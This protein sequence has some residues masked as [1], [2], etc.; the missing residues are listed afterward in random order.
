[1][2]RQWAER[3]IE[4]LLGVYAVDGLDDDERTAVEQHLVNCPRCAA[5]AAWHRNVAATLTGGGPAPPGVWDRIAAALE[6]PPPPLGLAPLTARQS[7][8]VKVLAPL[9]AMA[10]AAVA[11][12]GVGLQAQVR[13]LDRMETTM[14][15]DGLRRS[16]VAGLSEPSAR[17]L[18][19]GSADRPAA[20]QAAVLRDGR[21]Y[22][23][24][25]QLPPL[26]AERTYQLWILSD[27]ERISA[28][29]LG[30][31]PTVAVFHAGQGFDGLAITEEAATGVVVSRNAPVVF[32]R[33][34][35]HPGRRSGS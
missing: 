10:A 9:V 3:E 19:L 27:N 4:E 29:L 15:E 1:M 2:N 26:P 17:T 20:V 8:A 33:F 13:R 21:G 35:S 5:E 14:A 34:A 25:D 7:P 31:R 6:E 16:A 12:L 24:A 32:G 28:G 22:L 23:L 18:T 11:V 30:P